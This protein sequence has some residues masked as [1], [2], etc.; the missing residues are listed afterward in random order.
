MAQGNPNKVNA[1]VDEIVENNNVF[2]LKSPI[3][4]DK[5]KDSIAQSINSAISVLNEVGK[6]LV[7]QEL[8]VDPDEKFKG[9]I[10]SVG[11]VDVSGLS[12]MTA[13]IVK[14]KIIEAEKE[15]I[16]LRQG[17]PVFKDNTKS[18]LV[19]GVLTVAV[20]DTMIKNYDNLSD[21]EKEM[22]LDNY[23]TMSDD[24]REEFDKKVSESLKG[25]NLSETEKKEQESREREKN[26]NNKFI[27]LIDRYGKNYNLE[28]II[29]KIKKEYPEYDENE[30]KR[31]C[32]ELFNEKTPKQMV[33]RAKEINKNLNQKDMEL[34]KA[35]AIYEKKQKGISVS[36][37]E[38]K[39]LEDYMKSN[40]DFEEER[41]KV[42]IK[43]G[44][45]ILFKMKKG[46]QL[47]DEDKNIL[48]VLK[49][50]AKEANKHINQE[51]M[52]LD[53]AIVIYDKIQNGEQV[54]PEERKFLENY[55]KS[56]PRYTNDLREEEREEKFYKLEENIQE[57][58]IGEIKNGND[59]IPSKLKE[60]ISFQQ[61]EEQSKPEDLIKIELEQLPIALAKS[62][63]SQEDI[64]EAM[65]QY[66]TYFEDAS[67]DDFDFLAEQ[68]KEDRSDILKEEFEGLNVDEKT[69]EILK[70]M[71]ELTFDGNMQQILTNSKV[72]EQFLAQFDKVIEQGINLDQ[73]VKLDGELAQIFS[74]YFK[75]NAEEMDISAI[76]EQKEQVTDEQVKQDESKEMFSFIDSE[77]LKQDSIEGLI[78]RN[79]ENSQ[80]LQD[81]K[82]AIFYSQGKEGAIVMYFEFLKQYERLRGS[83]GDKALEQ[84]ANY[85][86]G[87]IE[88][89]DEQV[90]LLQGQ[91]KQITQMRE[92][93]DFDEFMGD[94]LYLKLNGI[95]TEQDR[96]AAEEW[97]ASHPGTIMDY[98]YANSWTNSAISPDRIDVVS[99]Q[100]KDGTDVRTSQ[101]DLIKYFL[102]QTSIDK[103]EELGVNDTTLENI[104]KYYQEHSTE[105]AQMGEEYS[106]VTQNIQEFEQSRESKET[107]KQ[108]ETRETEITAPEIEKH[109][110]N[111]PAKQDNSFLGKIK[112]VF[113]NM[114][115]MKNKDNSK[116]FFARLGASIQTV[117][118]NKKDEFDEKQDENITSSTT[119]RK[120]QTR[121]GSKQTNYL[122]QHFDVNEKQAVQDLKKKQDSKDKDSQLSQDDQEFGN[123]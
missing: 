54:S 21:K 91:L 85:K 120:E 74:Q 52:N 109:E 59:A 73:D 108:S 72:R 64:M 100:S 92:T 86:N 29:I 26:I 96:Q 88:L 68:T 27:R 12:Q 23:M 97:R 66:K 61:Q 76:E 37:E 34:D 49:K 50:I 9:F 1:I 20:I 25:K 80:S 99:L 113:A 35:I 42:R 94:K 40:P 31:I 14:E 46:Q 70:M 103:I 57:D 77:Y 82:K 123:L 75:D 106:V 44:Q 84:Y 41:G 18:L 60:E 122:T 17:Q 69:K 2:K 16:D 98:N 6:E 111:L 28:Q 39:F 116:G 117:F 3:E 95:D 58:N 45:Q 32:S 53:R 22:L 48:E 5:E 79:G 102:S 55:E 89:S 33:N 118:G 30:I 47:T 110:E 63:F 65:K 107:E 36:P 81:D 56:R 15:G 8:S 90:Q 11:N 87:T 10:D 7:L 38:N 93:K 101:K 67:N 13:T 24:D 121:E 4:Q 78:P 71:S 112:R 43:T 51:E 115:D 104:R 114:K 119:Q 83:A 19:G 105:I 62:N